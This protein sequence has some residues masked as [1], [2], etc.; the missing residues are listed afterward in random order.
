MQNPGLG[1]QNSQRVFV[2]V[3]VVHDFDLV[4]LH[5]VNH[6]LVFGQDERVQFLLEK[7]L[8]GLTVDVIEIPYLQ[9]SFI[10]A[11]NPALIFVQTEVLDVVENLVDDHWFLMQVV[12]LPNVDFPAFE[13]NDET[14]FLVNQGELEN[15]MRMDQ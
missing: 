15:V 1:I 8:P 2:E 3:S 12:Q 9:S 13:G 4:F 14:A 11:V 10:S 7:Q 5:E 6:L